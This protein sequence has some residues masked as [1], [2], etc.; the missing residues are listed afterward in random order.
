MS[1]ENT[2][3]TSGN[4]TI[5]RLLR[6]HQSENISVSPSG[7]STGVTNISVDQAIKGIEF[8]RNENATPA[9]IKTFRVV[10]NTMR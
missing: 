1:N 10:G 3:E 4:E 8:L 2:A 7:T 5:E 6:D 9:A